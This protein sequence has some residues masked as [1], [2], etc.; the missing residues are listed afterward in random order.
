[1]YINKEDIKKVTAAAVKRALVK[2]AEG[3]A[4]N[5]KDKDGKV[6]RR[7]VLSKKA[8]SF[9]A[10][11]YAYTQDKDGKDGKDVQTGSGEL[12]RLARDMATI[13]NAIVKSCRGNGGYCRDVVRCEVSKAP[14][15]NLD[16]GR[17]Y[18]NVYY[19]GKE[20]SIEM[21]KIIG[22]VARAVMGLSSRDGIDTGF[23]SSGAIGMSRQLDA[24]D[25]IFRIL[26]AAGGVYAQF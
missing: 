5:L 12:E 2:R 23:F 6:W 17:H 1:M 21:L 11:P 3:L 20:G 24:T 26:K 18:F 22:P 19:V 13:N 16:S 25:I 8:V 10:A 4:E 15:G 7:A 14:K 9:A